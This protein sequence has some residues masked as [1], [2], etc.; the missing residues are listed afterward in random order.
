M[1]FTYFFGDM[2]TLE[3]SYI[4]NFEDSGIVEGIQ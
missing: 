3:F 4:K 1:A 2:Q